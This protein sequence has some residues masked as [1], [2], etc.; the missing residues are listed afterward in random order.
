MTSHSVRYVS[1]KSRRRIENSQ[2]MKKRFFKGGYM[3]ISELKF[4]TPAMWDAAAN[5]SLHKAQE[6]EV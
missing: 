5:L 6:R 3:V 1:G 4:M 2:R